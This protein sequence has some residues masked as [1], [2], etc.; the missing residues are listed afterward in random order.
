LF[1]AAGR[2]IW[3]SVDTVVFTAGKRQSASGRSDRGQGGLQ[4]GLEFRGLH[5]LVERALDVQGYQA[6][7]LAVE[8][9]PS[10]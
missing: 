4:G 6:I 1:R 5:G 9:A 2:T 10:P 7:F 8:Q 3:P